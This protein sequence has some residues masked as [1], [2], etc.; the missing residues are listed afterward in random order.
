MRFRPLSS[1]RKAWFA[2]A[3]GLAIVVAI[4]GLAEVMVAGGT[5]IGYGAILTDGS[6]LFLENDGQF[7]S[8]VR[9]HAR[10]SQ[11]MLWIT[12]DGI[13]IT[14]LGGVQKDAGVS[15]VP[16]RGPSQKRAN[17]KLTFA[18]DADHSKLIPF[19]RSSTDFTIGTAQGPV[20]AQAW[21]GVSYTDIYDGLDMVIYGERGQWKWRLLSQD[22]GHRSS[23]SL[24]ISGA[25]SVSYDG[26]KIALETPAGELFLPELLFQQTSKTF[27][28]RF[29][30]K[31]LDDGLWTAEF[32][33]IG[34]RSTS[35][36]PDS[37]LE[38]SPTSG[39][40][41]ETSELNYST[42]FG[43]NAWD[44]GNS[45]ALDDEG[46]AYVTGY[47]EAIT[48][49]SRIGALP[50]FHG[51]DVFVFKLSQDGSELKYFLWFFT[52]ALFAE[53][54]GKDIAVDDQGQAYIVGRT[55]SPDF[56]SFFG[57]V[58]GYDQ[59]YNGDGDAYLL[60]IQP[61]GGGLEYC[62]YLG[63]TDIEG[64]NG[65]E[66]DSNENSYITGGT[67]STDFPTTPGAYDQQHN[68]LRDVFVT[69]VD[70]TGLSLV[71]STFLGGSGQDEGKGIDSGPDGEVYVTG[72][73]TSPDFDTT[74]GSVDREFN[75]QW[76]AFVAKMGAAGD[77]LNYGSY[78]GGV[79]EDRGLAIT[80][81][82][83]GAAFTTGMT[84]SSDFPTTPGAFDG[85]IG[86]GDCGPEICADGYVSKIDALGAN[87]DYS[88]FIGGDLEDSAH[89]LAVDSIGR[90]YVTGETL[91]AST[92]PTTT[93]AYDGSHNG[94]SDAFFSA[95]S[96]F[97]SNLP[98][99]TFL[100][101]SADDM[102][103]GVQI[104]QRDLAYLTGRT[105]SPDF[106]TTPEAFDPTH[107]GDN[108]AFVTSL[109]VSITSRVFLPTLAKQN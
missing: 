27:S 75:G 65:L 99:S 35:D 70:S 93:N 2:A 33:Y 10:S 89:S 43:S 12:E 87:L 14:Y 102:G 31:S 90:A 94:G 61:G 83:K 26:S 15:A 29:V 32:Q 5:Q 18:D 81:D 76:D 8:T 47:T 24:D 88:T 67:W 53:D 108:D 103:Y 1:R 78:L 100:G 63:G 25:E 55:H 45:I 74:P 72:W 77:E 58:P 13:W 39:D 54:Y 96:R 50:E 41:F 30:D 38:N 106:P 22:D 92:F 104:N 42:F 37:I 3:I 57:S 36:F 98:Y 34:E 4:L 59:T 6:V 71:Y 16:E 28:A 60:K 86:E 79:E 84:R 7:D 48:F 95:V 40:D 82:G 64:A 21:G 52:S 56:C 80:T 69:K 73:T 51:I 105:Q 44:E 97:G 85:T 20:S 107:N 11:G 46:H 62:T 19:A 17:V 68:G 101:G 66:I 91:S 23:V 9:Y 109:T 49:T